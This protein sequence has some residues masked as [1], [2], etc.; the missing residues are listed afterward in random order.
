MYGKCV[1][2]IIASFIGQQGLLK[3]RRANTCMAANFKG[4][5]NTKPSLVKGGE[6]RT[7]C[8][9]TIKYRAQG[10]Q[11]D[12]LLMKGGHGQQFGCTQPCISS[13][14]INVMVQV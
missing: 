9:I 12:R 4:G 13:T 11:K 14:P 10:K 1:V 6:R 3:A 8:I 7:P 5:E 2:F